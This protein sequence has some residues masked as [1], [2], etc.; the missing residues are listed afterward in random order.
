MIITIT[1]NPAVDKTVEIADFQVGTV[2]RVSSVRYD[3]GGKGINVSKVIQS[4]GGKS[5]AVGILGGSAG[6]FIQE[7]LERS[8]IENDFYFIKGETRTN[9]KVVDH[10]QK[11]NTDIN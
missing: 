1:L 8:G 2:N 4:L 9:V 5:K 10:Y 3:A 7:F 11:T 6:S